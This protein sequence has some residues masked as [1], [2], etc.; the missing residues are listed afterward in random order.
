MDFEYRKECLFNTNRPYN[1]DDCHHEVRE[2]RRG[3]PARLLRRVA[4][5][6]DSPKITGDWSYLVGESFDSP[7]PGLRSPQGLEIGPGGREVGLECKRGL[8]LDDPFRDLAGIGQ[9]ELPGD[10]FE[11]GC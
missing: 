7:W 4:S 8:V 2:A 11:N 6:N 3:D 9:A 10:E 5:R 1:V